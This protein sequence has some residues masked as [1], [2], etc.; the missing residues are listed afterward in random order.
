MSV[1]GKNCVSDNVR[2]EKPVGELSDLSRIE[3]G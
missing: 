3:G 1:K 2:I